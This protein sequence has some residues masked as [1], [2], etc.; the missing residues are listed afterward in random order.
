[1]YIDMQYNVYIISYIYIYHLHIYIYNLY[2]YYLY[3][4]AN[5][6]IYILYNTIL[7]ISHYNP[8]IPRSSSFGVDPS[9]GSL[10]PRGPGLIMATERA[11]TTRT[12]RSWKAV[13]L[14]TVTRSAIRP[15][16]EPNMEII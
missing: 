14:V 3:I 7:Y 12:A 2:I 9:F 15:K 11:H 1:M 4:Y 8:I 10:R 16:K 13:G 5:I 6:Y